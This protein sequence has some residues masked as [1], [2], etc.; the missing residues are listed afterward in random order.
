[1]DMELIER[2]IG[3]LEASRVTELDFTAG[4]TRVRI[5]R[6][7]AAAHASAAMAAGAP[8]PAPARAPGADHRIA[9]GMAGTFFRAAGPGHAPFVSE[10]DL[11]QDGQTIAILEAMKMLN[12]VEADVAGRITRILVENGTSVAAGTPLFVVALPG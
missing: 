4:T 7:G 6:H 10:G 3:L 5:E 8:P 9:A 2:L 11:V 12:P 1:M